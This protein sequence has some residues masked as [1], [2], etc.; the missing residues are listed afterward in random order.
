MA[1][2]KFE[3]EQARLYA[4]QILSVIVHLHKLSIVHRDLRPDNILIGQDG[5]VR[6]I[7]IGIAAEIHNQNLPG[8]IIE[9]DE[10]NLEEDKH[11]DTISK[12]SSREDVG[13][14]YGTLKKVVG[15][16][17]WKPPEMQ[18]Q[19]GY[20]YSADFWNFGVILY[21]FLVGK[22]PFVQKGFFDLGDPDKSALSRSEKLK[23]PKNI[24]DE[25]KDLIRRLCDPNP[26]KRLGGSQKNLFT[27]LS[28]QVSRELAEKET[29]ASDHID[30]RKGVH[31]KNESTDSSF[32]SRLRSRSIGVQD[33]N[34]QR[35]GTDADSIQTRSRGIS[36]AKIDFEIKFT[37]E[38]LKNRFP[39]DGLDI[40]KH[41]FFASIDWESIE[42]KSVSTSKL[43]SVVISQGDK[44]EFTNLKS[45][46]D[47]FER[48]DLTS[49]L[50]NLMLL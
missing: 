9:D 43:K 20:D 5:C 17:G 31:S 29:E 36:D 6:L 11:G 27:L 1:S 35:D 10:E 24:P 12:G 26:A 42:N 14:K 28:G 22:H 2:Q 7:D 25:A 8:S 45:V 40:R 23:F 49:N 38:E 50:E 46:L 47:D 21:V 44:P 18:K 3:I 19:E 39:G 33:Q 32:F 34:S 15:A 16:S 30:S 48:R 13:K 41:P 37:E 4:A